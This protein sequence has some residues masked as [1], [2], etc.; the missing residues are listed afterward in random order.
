M[1][2]ARQGKEIVL[3]EVNRVGLLSDVAKAV[4]Q[5]GISILA[6]TGSV[7]GADCYIHLVTDDN[8]RACDAISEQGYKPVEEGVILIELAHK[9]GMLKRLGEVLASDEIDIRHVYAT[10]L[11]EQDKCLLVLRTSNDEHA[12]PWLN[13]TLGHGSP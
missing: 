8:L 13:K 5:K 2:E 7:H 4:A 11:E 3:R 10:V 9:P 6:I 12:L 1:F